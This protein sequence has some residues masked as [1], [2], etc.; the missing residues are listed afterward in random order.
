[1]PRTTA[2]GSERLLPVDCPCAGDVVDS[3]WRSARFV[4]INL[5]YGV[6]I[7]AGEEVR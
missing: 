2:G 4:V 6:G 7:D 3:F 5:C 1:M